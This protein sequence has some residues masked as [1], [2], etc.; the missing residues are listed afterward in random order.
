MKKFLL[1]LILL[2]NILFLI[3]DKK[4]YNIGLLVVATGRYIEF[5]PPLI[6]SAEKYFCRNHTVTYF[7]FTDGKAPEADNVVSIYQ[8]R[9]GWPYDTMMRLP[10]YYKNQAQYKDMDYLFACDADMLFVGEVGDEILGDLVGTM[11]PGYVGR[12][13]TYETNP[14]STAF[15]NYNEGTRYYA[16][17]FNGGSRERFLHLAGTITQNIKTDLDK[18][19]IA[20]W[21]D[22]SHINRYFAT[23]EPTIVLTPSYCYWQGQVTQWPQKLVALSKDHAK[24]RAG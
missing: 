24:Y 18:G 22:E 2:S 8:N 15:I 13:G 1:F 16:G 7:V 17:G 23:Y 12:R 5:V 19:I 14:A 10:M 21:H 20:V 3:A 6:E 11:H 4:Q 9:L